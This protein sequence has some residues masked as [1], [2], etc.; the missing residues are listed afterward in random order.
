[1]VVVGG[2]GGERGSPGFKIGYR[3]DGSH[4]GLMMQRVD[5]TENL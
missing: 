1:M 4:T 5:H 3:I 2:R